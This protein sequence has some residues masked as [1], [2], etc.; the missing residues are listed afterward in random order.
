MDNGLPSI[1]G[2]KLT[3]VLGEGGMGVVYCGLREQDG[4]KV[5]IK[6]IRKNIDDGLNIAKRRF[7]RELEVCKKFSHPYVVKVI[8]GA[9]DDV[10]YLI[11]EL[12]D[13]ETLFHHTKK[14]LLSDSVARRILTQ[15]AE[16]LHYVHSF[17]LLH[18]DVKPT[19]LFLDRSG[20]TVLI[21]FGL[22]YDADQTRLTKEGATVGSFLALA[23]E[24]LRGEEP[25]PASDIYG[26]GVSL[27]RATTGKFP[28]EIADIL[29]LASG[30]T[31]AS[32]QPPCEMNGQLSTRLSNIILNCIAIDTANRYAS[33]APLLKALKDLKADLPIGLLS[34][35]AD[36]KRPADGHTKTVSNKAMSINKA[37]SKLIASFILLL[38]LVAI[39]ILGNKL[40]KASSTSPNTKTY[41]SSH[42]RKMLVD[43]C[44]L[45]KGLPDEQSLARLGKTL[46]QEGDEALA[47]K[48]ALLY[49]APLH[50]KEGRHTE[51]AL[52]FAEI[53]YLDNEDSAS[54]RK[55][56]SNSQL[57]AS[58]AK[59]LPSLMKLTQMDSFCKHSGLQ[60]L[61]AKSL[62]DQWAV[63][64]ERARQNKSPMRG[65]KHKAALERA[66]VILKGLTQ[67]YQN[68]ST[69]ERTEAMERFFTVCSLLDGA[70]KLE[71]VIETTEKLLKKSIDDEAAARS[72]LR[73]SFLVAFWPSIIK[74]NIQLKPIHWLEQVSKS[75]SNRELLAYAHALHGLAIIQYTYLIGPEKEFTVLFDES[76]RAV[77]KS[78]AL[79]KSPEM[80]VVATA[81]ETWSWLRQDNV[82][83][84]KPLFQSL[85]KS[86]F[87]ARHR[88]LYHRV[89]AA[90]C[91]KRFKL[92]PA[93]VA[94]NKAIDTAPPELRA[95]ITR[96][97][98]AA[99]GLGVI[100][101]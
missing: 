53:L 48:K 74:K 59:L 79:A 10:P 57:A 19:N 93:K 29:V 94:I 15:A 70:D 69:E 92:K 68:L 72:V 58:K 7:R 31:V 33:T 65:S 45:S 42:V 46:I 60:L 35:G 50:E 21:D 30:R 22:A 77:S 26:L 83:K 81:I 47:I 43:K 61:F 86:V 98:V 78:K 8:D 39:F 23:P 12:L 101:Q 87:P 90:F 71:I 34:T 51:A 76:R 17:S 14:N 66:F 64:E 82:E 11:M 4:L 44:L 5:A 37:R 55:L 24:I 80:E 1:T 28:N 27:Y 88:W 20:R 18:R 84:A 73:G 32:P 63:E 95:S 41:Q 75:I 91:F 6:V 52:H 36:K 2:Y 3:G 85:K 40:R 56:I 97:E 99:F 13:G 25:T 49:L 62:I 9:A 96:A 100:G 54:L 16:G 67:D 38:G 89:E